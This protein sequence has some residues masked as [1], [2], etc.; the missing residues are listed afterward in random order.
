MDDEEVVDNFCAI[1]GATNRDKVIA[2]VSD[3]NGNLEMAIESFF[4]VSA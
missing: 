3:M 1:T 4:E 2:F